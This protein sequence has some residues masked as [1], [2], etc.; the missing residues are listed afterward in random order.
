MLIEID[1]F[2]FPFFFPFTLNKMR[3]DENQWPYFF[4]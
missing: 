1:P 2:S 4:L 3:L